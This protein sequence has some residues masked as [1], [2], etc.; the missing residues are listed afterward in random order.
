[1]HITYFGT[2]AA[3]NKRAD[4]MHMLLDDGMTQLY[5]D[6][7]GGMSLMQKI[8][9]EET[10]KPCHIW[11]THCHSD[12]LLWL[13]HVLR[14]HKQDLLTIYCTVEI[15]EKIWQLMSIV[16]QEKKY[17]A[18]IWVGLIRY[19]HIDTTASVEIGDRHIIPY[20]IHS[21]K[22]TQYG[23]ILSQGEH[24]I[25]CI[26]DEAIEIDAA[27]DKENLAGSTWFLC[28]A[29]CAEKD[30]ESRK[31]HEISHITAREA[32]E[33]ATTLHAKNLIISHVDDY[34]DNRQQQ[35]LDVKNEAEEGF[36]GKVVVP[37]DGECITLW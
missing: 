14:I 32:G 18:K 22:T 35:L 2:W 1:M 25:V 10:P 17:R 29:F 6:A 26:G 23:F 36:Y 30:A 7:G 12:H 11:I 34:T 5:V 33:L 24:I 21:R 8:L 27:H 31:P 13:V 15:E 28:E 3:L 20:N 4:T 37:T 16:G 19:V 9:C